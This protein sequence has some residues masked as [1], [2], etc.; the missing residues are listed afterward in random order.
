MGP[1]EH[2][3][4]FWIN[5][6][7][8]I[9][10][11][12]HITYIWCTLDWLVL[13]T[14]IQFIFHT[15]AV[16]NRW[17]RIGSKRVWKFI[18]KTFISKCCFT[19]YTTIFSLQILQQ[20]VF[21]CTQLQPIVNFWPSTPSEI[22][23]HIFWGLIL[24]VP[25]TWIYIQVSQSWFMSSIIALLLL[26]LLLRKKYYIHNILPLG[27]LM[28]PIPYLHMWDPFQ[29]TH[30]VKIILSNNILLPFCP[31]VSTYSVVYTS[32]RW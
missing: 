15:G 22:R 24:Y 21:K 30:L 20:M 16:I 29:V 2:W 13:T 11:I 18:C 26:F 31:L 28:I 19:L 27:S 12:H 17:Q 9:I 8:H 23:H 32:Y 10:V 14:S 6:N 4:V 3:I 25:C 1:T 7:L 5:L